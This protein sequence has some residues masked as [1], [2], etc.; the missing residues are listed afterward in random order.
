MSGLGAGGTAGAGAVCPPAA[1]DNST[2][3]SESKIKAPTGW[4]PALPNRCCFPPRGALQ[5]GRQCRRAWEVGRPAGRWAQ[6]WVS[7]GRTLGGARRVP[8][9]AEQRSRGTEAT[10]LRGARRSARGFP[11]CARMLPAESLC[12]WVFGKAVDEESPVPQLP[13]NP[14]HGFIPHPRACSGGGAERIS[15]SLSPGG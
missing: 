11:P 1:P 12:P 6:G 13:P 5:A 9:L 14:H 7:P 10:P 3:A 15:H 8:S 2:S 4:Y